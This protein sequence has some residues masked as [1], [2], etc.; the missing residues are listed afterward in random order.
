MDHMDILAPSHLAT[1]PFLVGITGK[2]V[3][4]KIWNWGLQVQTISWLLFV[5]PPLFFL[6]PPSPYL[7]FSSS[8]PLPLPFLFF[9]SPLPL[10]FLFFLSPPPPTFPFIPLPPSPYLSFYSSPPLFFLSS[11]P[12]PFLFFLSPPPPT[13]P[14]LPCSLVAL[15]SISYFLAV[16]LQL[17]I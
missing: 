10:P 6:S 12:L 16:G 9:L 2:K 8:P 14:F 17:I 5:P 1:P 7:S 11:L 3:K 4:M 15:W 13:F